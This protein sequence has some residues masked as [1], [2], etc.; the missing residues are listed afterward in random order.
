V[1]NSHGENHVP[2][3]VAVS[4]T[5][6]AEVCNA[7]APAASAL[8]YAAPLAA[9]VRVNWSWKAAAFAASA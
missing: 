3:C 4:R 1:T 8:V 7:A 6:A 5:D 9:M 2:D